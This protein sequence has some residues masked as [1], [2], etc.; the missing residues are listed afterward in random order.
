VFNYLLIPYK[1]I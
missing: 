1:F